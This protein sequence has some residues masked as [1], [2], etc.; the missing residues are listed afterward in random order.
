MCSV[1][2]KK[3]VNVLSG[4]KQNYKEKVKIAVIISDKY[5]YH[6]L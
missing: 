5:T 3:W 4:I 6:K 2:R 1:I